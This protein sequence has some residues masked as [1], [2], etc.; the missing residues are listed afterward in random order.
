MLVI[1]SNKKQCLFKPLFFTFFRLQLKKYCKI[2][3]FYFTL[4]FRMTESLSA[5]N[6]SLLGH[7]NMWGIILDDSKNFEIIW[8]K[9]LKISTFFKF[10]FFMLIVCHHRVFVIFLVILAAKM[11]PWWPKKCKIGPE[12]SISKHVLFCVKYKNL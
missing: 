4:R 12:R 6:C 1:F 9:R 10:Y 7:L 11:R 8:A 3:F 2:A 5:P